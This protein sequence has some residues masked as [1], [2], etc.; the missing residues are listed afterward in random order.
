MLL[1]VIR[2][3]RK[4][5]VFSS[6]SFIKELILLTIMNKISWCLKQDKGLKLV[7]PNEELAYAYLK[8]AES[9][10]KAMIREKDN[11]DWEISAAYYTIYFSIYAVMKRLGVDSKIH[12]CTIAFAKSF[13]NEIFS[14][15]ELKLFV[16]A[17]D[18]REEAQ[19]YT[20]NING[21]KIVVKAKFFLDKCSAIIDDKDSLKIIKASIDK[22][23]L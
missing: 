7:E 3:I 21:S 4:K 23:L 9:S 8:K 19:Y 13:L 11:P 10:L 16:E 22:T 6:D 5:S 20:N 18:L 15:D 17:K 1:E 14:F 12:S 2:F